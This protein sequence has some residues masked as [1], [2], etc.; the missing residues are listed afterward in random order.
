[1]GIGRRSQVT[2]LE[3]PYMKEYDVYLERR[4]KK[5]KRLFRR[6]A[7]FGVVAFI[8]VTSLTSYHFNQRALKKEK[9]G[10]LIELQNEKDQLVDKQKELREEIKLLQDEDYVL[11]IARRDYFFSNEGE[12]IF[13]LPDEDPSY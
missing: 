12:V 3:S 10:E 13:K 6:L 2:K 1:M 7:L 5:R 8:M 4:S 11:Q 9:V